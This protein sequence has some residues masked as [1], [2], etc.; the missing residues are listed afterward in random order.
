MSVLIVDY[1]MGN[2]GSVRR[3]IEECGGT[4]F[5]SNNP[6]DIEEARHII[7]PGVGSFSDGMKN[8]DQSNWVPAIKTAVLNNIPLLGICLGM[9]L[10]ADKG[11]ENGETEGL[12]LIS[13]EVI[14][15]QSTHPNERIPHV[16]W[17]EVSPNKES[18][19]LEGIPE[20]SDF[21]FVH[22]FHFKTTETD[23]IVAETP[24]CNSFSS[25]VE[26]GLVC[27]VQFHPEKSSHW[28]FKLLKNFLEY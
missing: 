21:Y 26:D 19:L 23:S 15:L 7:L 18:D 28:G 16:G 3:A 4:T 9:H 25:V 22:S 12:A 24:Y 13:G 14:P 6:K 8:L 1:G 2:L 11:F 27:G 10:L 20:N 17:N 5:I